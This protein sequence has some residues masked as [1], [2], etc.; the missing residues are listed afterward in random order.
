[1]LL[2]DWHHKIL[3]QERQKVADVELNMKK[4]CEQSEEHVF[5]LE[6]KL[7]DLSDVVGNYEHLRTLDQQVAN[8][9]LVM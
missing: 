7:S 1:M 5:N 4:Q 3:Q 2:Q 9:R 6:E 8:E